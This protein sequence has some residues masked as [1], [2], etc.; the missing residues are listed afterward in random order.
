M[1]IKLGFFQ[2]GYF[3]FGVPSFSTPGWGLPS[4][5]TDEARGEGPQA[6]SPEEPGARPGAVDPGG[7]RVRTPPGGNLPPGARAALAAHRELLQAADPA[8]REHIRR[9]LH[10]AERLWPTA[11]PTPLDLSP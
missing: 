7:V 1:G 8:R 10:D 9:R 5:E 2:Y 11:R 3:Q 6:D 4:E